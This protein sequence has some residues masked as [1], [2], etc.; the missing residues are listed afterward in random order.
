[1][2]ASFQAC[3]AERGELRLKKMSAAAVTRP[4]GGVG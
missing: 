4:P 1:M 2:V 3:Y